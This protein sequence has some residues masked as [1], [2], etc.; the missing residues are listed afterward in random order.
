[1]SQGF[2]LTHF[3]CQAEVT[4]TATMVNRP[5]MAYSLSSVSRNVD[6]SFFDPSRQKMTTAGAGCFFVCFVSVCFEGH[7]RDALNFPRWVQYRK[8]EYHTS[9][10]PGL[11]GSAVPVVSCTAP[12][13]SEHSGWGHPLD[14]TWCLCPLKFAQVFHFYQASC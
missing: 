4:E 6:L 13:Y 1:M 3:K 5:S 8:G 9:I 2:S 7:S 11:Q 12:V 10:C 14:D